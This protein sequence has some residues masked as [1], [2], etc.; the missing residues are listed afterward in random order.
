MNFLQCC[1]I[2]NDNTGMVFVSGK[3]LLLG[4]EQVFVWELALGKV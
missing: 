3:E 2:L 4:K 1:R